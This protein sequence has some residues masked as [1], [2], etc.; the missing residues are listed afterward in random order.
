MDMNERRKLQNGASQADLRVDRFGLRHPSLKGPRSPFDTFRKGL[1]QPALESA[2][3]PGSAFCTSSNRSVVI[4][5]TSCSKQEAAKP[6]GLVAAPVTGL[7][8]CLWL[9]LFKVLLQDQDVS[10]LFT[11]W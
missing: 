1:R 2:G 5:D 3:G 9:T 8:F 4:I 6:T 11:L 7:R 10:E